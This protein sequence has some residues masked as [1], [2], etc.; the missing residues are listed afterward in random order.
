[1]TKDVAEAVERLLALANLIERPPLDD[2]LLDQSVAVNA[3]ADIR[4]VS[5]T[6][7][8]REAELAAVREATRDCLAVIDMQERRDAGEFHL[9]IVAFRPIWDR[10]KARARQTLGDQS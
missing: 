8:A 10:A 5:A 4:A 9:S 3:A 6:L 2:V 1:M 7:S